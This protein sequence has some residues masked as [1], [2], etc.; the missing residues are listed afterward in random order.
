[1]CRH[2]VQFYDNDHFLLRKVVEFVGPAL[3]N[4][5]SAIVVATQPHLQRLQSLLDIKGAGDEGSRLP[6]EQLVCL[7]A[8]DTLARFMVNGLPDKQRFVAVV[9]GL[10]ARC[11]DDGRRRVSAFGEMVAVLYA[12]GNT[13]AASR[14][15]VLWE[16]LFEDHAFALLCAYPMSAFPDAA[17]R[18]AFDAIC[19]V[20]SRVEP[21]EP[22]E[23]AADPER[24]HGTVARL[25]QA[26]NSLERE[27]RRRCESDDK[28]QHQSARLSE[29]EYLV[30]HD[31]L[32]GL[33][34][35]R[36]FT[37]RLAQAYANAQRMRSRLALLFVDLDAFKAVNDRFGHVAGDGLLKEVAERLSRCVRSGDAGRAIEIS[38]DGL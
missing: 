34:N 3:T 9:G 30:G 33:G 6:T 13:E 2:R 20:H 15:E 29:L 24:V 16:G 31:S 26:A 5:G 23:R 38:P 17:H 8:H 18:Q 22:V 37:E 36:V 35:R 1:M 21:L 12:E 11:S 28:L 32:T 25:Q 7:D 10:L 14:L 4:G 27:V 19:E